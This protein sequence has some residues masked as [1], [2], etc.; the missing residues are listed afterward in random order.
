MKNKNKKNPK[1][2]DNLF[3]Q[4]I[5][6]KEEEKE[7]EESE[8]EEGEE[9]NQEEDVEKETKNFLIE[10]VIHTRVMDNREEIKKCI[11]HNYLTLNE[12][13]LSE[14]NESDSRVYF[15]ALEPGTFKA[16]ATVRPSINLSRAFDFDI[17]ADN[18]LVLP[19][20]LSSIETEAFY[21]IKAKKIKLPAHIAN[22]PEG[23]FDDDAVFIH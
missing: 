16:K 7:N 3:N 11:C 13:K 19:D 18:G 5:E 8:E 4:R 14:E 2:D 6:A 15:T 21:G 10:L 1:E 17:L 22:P 9:E 20:Q 23:V 12:D